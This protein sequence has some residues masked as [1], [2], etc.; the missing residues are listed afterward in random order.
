MHFALSDW[1]FY[2]P[3]LGELLGDG[4][5]ALNYMGMKHIRQQSPCHRPYVDTRM[6]IK[7]PV[8][9]TQEG[10]NQMARTVFQFDDLSVLKP[11]II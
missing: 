3:V 8:F 7:P 2:L 6:I 5:A 11:G 9:N 1:C 4:G 10:V